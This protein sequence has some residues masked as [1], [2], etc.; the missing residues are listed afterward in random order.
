[1]LGDASASPRL[2]ATARSA[3]FNV[4]RLRLLG[5]PLR[6]RA[7]DVALIAALSAAGAVTAAA[8]VVELGHG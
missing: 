2:L 8:S 3:S 4:A 7:R 6:L 1:M 5:A